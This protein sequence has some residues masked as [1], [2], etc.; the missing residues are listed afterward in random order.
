MLRFCVAPE[1][2]WVVIEIMVPFWIL[3]RIRHGNPKRDHNFDNHPH[4]S[5]NR[6][7]E[8]CSHFT[9]GVDEVACRFEA[10]RVTKQPTRG[11]ICCC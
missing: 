10:G 4:V 8:D 2:T 5:V 11:L 9:R 1:L 3:I 6:V 7:H